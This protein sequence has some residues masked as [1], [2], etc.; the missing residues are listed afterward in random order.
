MAVDYKDN[1]YVIVSEI[2]D[3]CIARA[4]EK[5]AAKYARY[6]KEGYDAYGL[7][8][9]IW[10]EHE[11]HFYKAYKDELGVSGFLD[12]GDLLVQGGKY[13]EASFAICSVKPFYNQFTAETFQRIGRWLD[14]GICNWAHTDVICS[15]LLSRF[16]EKD[17]VTLA[18]MSHWRQSPSK[19]KRRAVPVS[20]ISL[21]KKC[22]DCGILLEYIRPLMADGERVVQQGLGWFLREAWK[23]YPGPVEEFLAQWKDSSPRLIFQ[24][25]TEKM[26]P[27]NKARFRREKS[28]Q[29]SK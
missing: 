16:F 15:Q 9:D 7:P 23:R 10:K 28:K 17:L 14:T 25:A 12:L 29:I 19:W 24:Y 27:E 6:F 8:G 18:D 3:F 13:E 26:T 22:A 2:R 11:Y 5:Q 20:M 21:L 1:L 4:D